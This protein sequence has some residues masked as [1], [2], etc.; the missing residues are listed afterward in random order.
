M[1]NIRTRLYGCVNKIGIIL[2]Y[3][4]AFRR[5]KRVHFV[6]TRIGSKYDVFAVSKTNENSKI[7]PS[8]RWEVIER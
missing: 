5:V 7:Q 6:T 4:G 2:N 8:A 3:C 1:T